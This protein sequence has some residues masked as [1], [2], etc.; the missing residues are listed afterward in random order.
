MC[1]SSPR[2]CGRLCRSSTGS[3]AGWRFPI[4]ALEHHDAAG[5]PTLPQVPYR[6]I[7]PFRYIDHLIFFARNEEVRHLLH[8]VG[9]YRGVML[10]GGSGAGRSSLIN[11]GLFPAAVQMGFQPERVRVQPRAGEE[12]V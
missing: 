6:G 10:Y 12:L 1:A 7:Q 2:M 11:A 3:S 8:L 9:V 5:T 4:T